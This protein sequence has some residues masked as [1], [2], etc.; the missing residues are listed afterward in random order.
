MARIQVYGPVLRKAESTDLLDL[1]QGAGCEPGSVK[2]IDHIPDPIEGAEDV[3]LIVML[4]PEVI[5]DRNLEQQLAKAT[6][7]GRRV[8]CIWPPEAS[9][10]PAPASVEKY[11]YSLVSWNPDRLRSVL[12]DDDVICFETPAGNARPTPTTD[13][14]ICAEENSAPKQ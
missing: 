8:V 10:E 11:S 9:N 14:H 4:T 2:F 6:N 12:S 5:S 1:L 13:R 7:G 3:V